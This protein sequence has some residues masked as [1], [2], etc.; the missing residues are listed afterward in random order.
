MKSLSE[1]D[2]K[3]PHSAGDEEYEMPCAEAVLAGTLALMTGHAQSCCQAHRELM[4]HKVV[5]NLFILSQHPILSPG[6]KSMLFNLQARWSQQVAGGLQRCE[7]DPA[8]LRQLAGDSESTNAL[9]A[10][11][12]ILELDEQRVLWHKAPETAQ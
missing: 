12:A 8:T 1:H 9:Q 10:V 11:S 6:F 5:S 2:A 3:T 7:P 4:A